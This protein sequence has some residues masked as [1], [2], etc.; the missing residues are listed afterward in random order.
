MDEKD[1]VD[2]VKM[3]GGDYTLTTKSSQQASKL[4]MK[5]FCQGRIHEIFGCDEDHNF[6]ERVGDYLTGICYF[7]CKNEKWIM[8]CH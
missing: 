5:F 6:L 1:F 3:Q 7:A 2:L 8:K 4:Y